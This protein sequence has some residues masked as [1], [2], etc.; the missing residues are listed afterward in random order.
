MLK[1][2]QINF[3]IS[4]TEEVLITNENKIKKFDNIPN[5]NFIIQTLKKYI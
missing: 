1:F 3:K 5:E 2:Y 4:F